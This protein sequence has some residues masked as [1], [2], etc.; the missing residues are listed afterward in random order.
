MIWRASV[1]A[2]ACFTAPDVGAASDDPKLSIELNATE[3]LADACRLTFVLNNGFDQDI[4]ALM[5]ETVL[6]SAEGQVVLLTL[7]DFGTLPAQR[8]RVRQFEVA[9]QPCDSLGQVLVNGLGTCTIGGAPS[10]QCQNELS[11]SSRVRMA[12]E[13]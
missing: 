3:T 10:D 13:G 2:F 9:G 6:F 4:D 7:F 11:L 8:P 12:L 1:L 5:A